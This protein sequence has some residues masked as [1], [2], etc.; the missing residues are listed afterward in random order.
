MRKPCRRRDSRWGH[1]AGTSGFPERWTKLST[2]PSAPLGTD[3]GEVGG[4]EGTPK[5]G[6]HQALRSPSLLL[7]GCRWTPLLRGQRAVLGRNHECGPMRPGPRQGTVRRA[8]LSL[9]TSGDFC[10]GNTT[11]RHHRPPFALGFPL[12]KSSLAAQ[13][14]DDRTRLQALALP[15]LPTRTPAGRPSPPP[16]RAQAHTPPQQ[17]VQVSSHQRLVSSNSG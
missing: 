6:W 3:K 15:T 8:P 1:W 12:I 7:V 14:I 2:E 16:G 11:S 9:F 4:G 17:P 13:V 10:P 5:P